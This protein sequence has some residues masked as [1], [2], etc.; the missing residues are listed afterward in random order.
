MSS[1]PPAIH[2]APIMAEPSPGGQVYRLSPAGRRTALILLLGVAAIW[3]FAL[4]TLVTQA[5]DGLSGPE[6]VTAILM[7]GILVVAPVVGWT[8]LE[9]RTTTITTDARGLTYRSVGGIHLAYTWPEITGLEPAPAQPSRWA[10]LFM[11]NPASA[12]VP[13]TKEQS[14]AAGQQADETQHNNASP[15]VT[16]DSSRP[17]IST[18]ADAEDTDEEAY[19]ANQRTIRV[20]VRPVPAA[21]IANPALRALWQQAHGDTLPLPGELESREAVLATIRDHLAHQEPSP[22]A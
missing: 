5:Q 14:P 16:R 3:V 10:Q 6:W 20:A 21:R 9:E 2:A 13:P 17:G 8:L 12:V 22:P 11:D 15:T 1:E 18:P 19:E 4:W 7:L